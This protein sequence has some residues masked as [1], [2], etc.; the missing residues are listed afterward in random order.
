M[1]LH[2]RLTSYSTNQSIGDIHESISNGLLGIV[3]L[4]FLNDS[5]IHTEYCQQTGYLS[6]I[7]IIQKIIKSVTVITKSFK[8]T[9]ILASEFCLDLTN[10]STKL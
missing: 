2:S 4:L 8:E 9:N 6:I 7:I 10:L 3:V 5:N 1:L